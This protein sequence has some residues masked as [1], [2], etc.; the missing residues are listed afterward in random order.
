MSSHLSRMHT[1]RHRLLIWIGCGGFVTVG[2]VC[3]LQFSPDVFDSYL[4]HVTGIGR[5]KQRIVTFE[6]GP[7]DGE[8]IDTRN[9]NL[10]PLDSRM[11]FAMAAE[12]TSNGDMMLTISRDNKGKV[13]ATN[14]YVQTSCVEKCGILYVGYRYSGPSTFK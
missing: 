14:H 12:P 9:S 5:M 10:D 6:G 8:V 7:F 13:T 3:F 2:L 4:A 1:Q 11:T